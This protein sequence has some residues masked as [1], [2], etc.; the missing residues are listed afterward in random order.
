MKIL[1]IS[2][3][4]G[5]IQALEA[6]WKV[7]KDSDIVYCPGDLVDYGPY[8]KEAID[9]IREHGVICVR[10]NHDTEVASRYRNCD[11]E[12]LPVSETMWKHH[13]AIRLNEEKIS[14]LEQLPAAVDFC[15][16]GI[17]YGMT[18]LYREIDVITSPQVFD[19][20]VEETF[21]ENEEGLPTR[22]IVGHTHRLGVYYLSDTTLWLNAGSASYRAQ[23][24]IL[25][26]SD[27]SQ[28]AQY[29]TIVDGE[30]HL[31]RVAYDVAGVYDEMRKHRVMDSEMEIAIRLYGPR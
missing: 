2:D 16:D 17:R 13:N 3:I 21:P 4:H 9:W 20:F 8:P 14:F 29:I 11:L 12:R 25:S 22:L 19:R 6:I 30:I 23:R 27:P 24:D 5:N 26:L 28:D 10:G 18:H 7:E 1:I 15:A 31:K